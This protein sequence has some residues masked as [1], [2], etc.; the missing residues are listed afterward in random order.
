MLTQ[1]KR[2]LIQRAAAT[3][4]VLR[5][6]KPL[7]CIF[8][9][10][11]KDTMITLTQYINHRLGTTSKEQAINFLGKPFG[12]KSLA[13]FWQYWNPVWNYYLYYYCYKPLRKYLP[14]WTCVLLTFFLCG[15]LHDL[16]ISIL[17]YAVSGRPPFFTITFFLAINGIL[18][19]LTEKLNLRL[20]RVPIFWRW[21]THSAILLVGYQVALDVTTRIAT[22]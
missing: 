15:L 4:R 20:V 12:A 21:L 13:E 2:R 3:H 1:I 10:L 14:R 5:E 6:R 17:S 19:V 22:G 18:V 7:G 9:I 16:P 11:F 8:S